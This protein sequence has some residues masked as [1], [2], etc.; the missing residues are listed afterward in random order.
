MSET[1]LAT[2]FQG[3]NYLFYFNR[4][5]VE[6]PYSTNSRCTMCH[7]RA[8]LKP[9]GMAKGIYQRRNHLSLPHHHG[10][11]TGIVIVPDVIDKLT[12]VSPIA[13]E[14]LL[15]HSI[16]VLGKDCVLIVHKEKPHFFLFKE[17]CFLTYSMIVSKWGKALLS[18]Y[19]RVSKIVN[20]RTWHT[21]F[22]SL[23]CTREFFPI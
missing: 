18:A 9:V 3:Y 21:I 7:S 8:F 4:F 20:S 6:I 16:I 14:F 15:H 23:T 1:I 17:S 12:S 5:R 19:I 22:S 11:R 2:T 10:N 13:I